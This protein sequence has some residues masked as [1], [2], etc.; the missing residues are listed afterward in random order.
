MC[1]CI[2]EN[3]FV[4]L[5]IQLVW[6]DCYF[7][8]RALHWSNHIHR[9]KRVLNPNLAVS[10]ELFRFERRKRKGTHG[11]VRK[12]VWHLLLCRNCAVFNDIC[13]ID[14]KQWEQET[15]WT[16]WGLAL[17]K[18]IRD[19]TPGPHWWRELLSHSTFESQLCVMSS[20]VWVFYAEQKS[21]SFGL[22]FEKLWRSWPW[23]MAW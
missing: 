17:P 8:M 4:I 14:K 16:F 3:C 11:Q 21:V 2:R 19:F 6:C 23:S 22:G 9:R 20:V 15:A 1:V 7:G 5:Q 10:R 13:N 12:Q 18:S